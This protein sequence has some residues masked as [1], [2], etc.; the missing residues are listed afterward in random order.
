[1]ANKSS[2]HSSYPA[3]IPGAPAPIA[4]SARDGL[5]QARVEAR[6]FLPNAV[7]LLSGIAFSES[8]EASLHM[9]ML[10]TRQIVEI[11]GIVPAPAPAAPAPLHD[12]VEHEGHA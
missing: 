11:A 1:M 2:E 7:R 10:C 6:K 9:R 4:N 8:S 5:E 12:D 3:R